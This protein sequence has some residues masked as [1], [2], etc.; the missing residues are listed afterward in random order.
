[1]L[2]NNIQGP[3][4]FWQTGLLYAIEPYASQRDQVL[5]H[6]ELDE[7][8][9]HVWNLGADGAL[10]YNEFGEERCKLFW[11]TLHWLQIEGAGKD[12]VDL[13]LR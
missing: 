3:K 1:M 8:D 4:F 5:G 2:N 12:E 11:K 7:N 6:A 9:K 10:L 13:V